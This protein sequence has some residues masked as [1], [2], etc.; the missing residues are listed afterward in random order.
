MHE[1]GECLSK[2]VN[3]L[4]K[5]ANLRFKSA[6]VTLPKVSTSD[7]P[8]KGRVR[9]AER[10]GERRHESQDVKTGSWT[11]PPRGKGAKRVGMIITQGVFHNPPAAE[12]NEDDSKSLTCSI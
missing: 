3:A 9:E 1:L 12:R 6:E 4:D 7:F 5:C 2:L 10:P 11:G 8:R